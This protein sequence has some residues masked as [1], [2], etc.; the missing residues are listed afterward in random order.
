MVKIKGEQQKIFEVQTTKDTK[1]DGK[2]IKFIDKKTH[3]QL[4]F[5]SD[6]TFPD[7]QTPIYNDL[8]I[9]LKDADKSKE[10]HVWINSQGGSVT[11]LML[12][13]QL[14]EQFEYIVTLGT[15]QIDSAGFQFWA[16]GD[17]RYLSPKTFCM[18]HAMTSGMIG[19]AKQVKDYGDFIERYQQIFMNNV[20]TKNI[21]TPQEIEKGK[22]TQVWLLGKDLIERGVAIDYSQY[23]NRQS[24]TKIQGFKMDQSFYVKDVEGKYYQCVLVN[25]G[26][27]KRQIM[28]LY[29]QNLKQNQSKTNVIVQKVGQDFLQFIQNWIRLKGRILDGDGF[30]SN[31]ELYESY[32]GML[33]PISLEQIKK[34]LKDWCQLVNLE[35]T[36]SV[37]R[38]KKKGFLIK[39]K[40]Q[41]SQE[42]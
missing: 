1:Y 13:S 8:L 5:T 20:I 21:L 11:T 17:E 27:Q 25:V 10:I 34:K 22:L 33:Q 41:Q 4:I 39:V 38:N 32:C 26:Q 2:P 18:Y 12:L 3:Y 6:F 7:Q 15:G 31:D 29:L 28:K 35:Y 23:K 19:K 16:M 37:T 36:N 42:E 14:I 30:I 9:D 24:M 40:K